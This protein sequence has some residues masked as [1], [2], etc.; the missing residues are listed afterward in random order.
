MISGTTRSTYA[1]RK[2]ELAG[3]SQMMYDPDLNLNSSHMIS[4]VSPGSLRRPTLKN[5]P[6]NS[7]GTG[8]I[9]LDLPKTPTQMFHRAYF[10]LFIICA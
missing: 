6:N 7:P 10:L 3:A 4:Y 9:P 1:E 8:E 2:A 5:R